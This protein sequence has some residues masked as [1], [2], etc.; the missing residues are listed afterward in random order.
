MRVLVACAAM[1]AMS[2]QAAGT[3]IGRAWAARG[4]EVAVVPMQ[5]AEAGLGAPVVDLRRPLPP[6][7]TPGVVGLVDADQLARP[8]TGLQGVAAERGRHEGWNLADVLAEDARLVA[9][10][11]EIWPACPDAPSIPGGGAHGGAGLRVLAAGGRLTT[12]AALC[13]EAAGLVATARQADI[14]VSGC[15]VFEFGTFGGEVVAEV[16]R[17][18][19]EVARPLVVLSAANYVSARELRAAGIEAVHAAR[20]GASSAPITVGELEQLADRVA[21]SWTWT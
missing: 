19:T 3:L 2:S 7:L 20:S 16:L 9:W 11:H 5:V 18:A 1:G 8:L 15:D 21:A 17:V 10:A 4:A 13:A 12:E 6:E 14:V